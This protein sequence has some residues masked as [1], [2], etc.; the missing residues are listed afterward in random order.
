MALALPP[1]QPHDH[2]AANLCVVTLEATTYQCEWSVQA[3]F[4]S[5]TSF[6][7]KQRGILQPATQKHNAS[8][9]RNGTE[10]AP[11]HAQLERTRL[12]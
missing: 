2:A 10:A 1:V 7:H 11:V 12:K 5:S 4:N 3:H 6:F 8:G 9:S